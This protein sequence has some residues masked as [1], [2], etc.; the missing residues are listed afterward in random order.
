MSIVA[1]S[2]DFC[3]C[4]LLPSMLIVIIVHCCRQCGLLIL[5]IVVVSVDWYYCILFLSMLIDVIVHCVNSVHCVRRQ[6]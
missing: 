6:Y 5:S 3:D 1:V 2:V 4:R